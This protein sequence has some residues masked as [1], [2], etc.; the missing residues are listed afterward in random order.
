MVTD[1]WRLPTRILEPVV[2]G[3]ALV[4]EDRIALVT[5]LPRRSP[6][7]PLIWFRNEPDASL[8]F[9]ALPTTTPRPRPAA[10]PPPPPPRPRPRPAVPRAKPKIF[11][12]PDFFFA[13]L[14]TWFAFAF[15]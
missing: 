5:I 10:P 2:R 4:V 1:W 12:T 7:P 15:P 9:P 8:P 6:L 3:P 11:V 14:R 13:A